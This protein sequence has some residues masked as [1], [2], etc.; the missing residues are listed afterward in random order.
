MMTPERWQHVEQLYEAALERKADDRIAF[1]DKACG[2]DH[3]LRRE[4]ESL[5][6]A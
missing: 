4:V 5:L 3:V 6:Q 1:L 2:D